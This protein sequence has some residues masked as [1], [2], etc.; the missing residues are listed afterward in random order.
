M[1]NLQEL[2]L[3]FTEICLP[4]SVWNFQS[5]YL[6]L[7]STYKSPSVG[8]EDVRRKLDNRRMEEKQNS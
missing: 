6:D 3:V 1:L 4:Y 2:K 5:A 8:E 7:L